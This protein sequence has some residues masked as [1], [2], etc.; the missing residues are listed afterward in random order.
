MSNKTITVDLIKWKKTT[1]TKNFSELTFRIK[2]III[3]AN[4]ICAANVLNDEQHGTAR[5]RD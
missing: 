5:N 4:K 3:D 2:N 1:L